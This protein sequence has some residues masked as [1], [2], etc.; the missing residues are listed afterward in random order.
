MRF[1]TRREISVEGVITF[2]APCSG[3]FERILPAGEILIVHQEPPDFAK[4]VYL[5]PARYKDFELLF[6]PE[7]DRADPVYSGYAVVCSF[8]RI[9]SDLEAI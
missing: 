5:V 6:V 8:E 2:G 1:R 4:G 9:G 7:R 3:G